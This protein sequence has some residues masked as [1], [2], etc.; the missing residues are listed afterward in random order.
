MVW[1]QLENTEDAERYLASIGEE[2][3]FFVLLKRLGDSYKE[4]G[5]FDKAIELYKKIITRDPLSPATPEIYLSLAVCYDAKN[6]HEDLIASLVSAAKLSDDKTG[7]SWLKAQDKSSQAIEEARKA[8]MTA[9]HLYGTRIHQSAEKIKAKVQADKLRSVA[10]AIYLNYVNFFPDSAERPQ[11]QTYLGRIYQDQEKWLKASRTYT[12][13]LGL[14][15][16]KKELL[17]EAAREAIISV[18]FAIKENPPPAPPKGILEKEMPIPEL[19][20]TYVGTLS[21]YLRVLP[22]DK[23]SA[24]ILYIR[25][26]TFADYGYYEKALADFRLLTETHPSSTHAN[27][28]AL[29]AVS[30]YVQRMDWT[31][32]IKQ[33]EDFLKNLS[34]ATKATKAS[35]L[36]S[37]EFSMFSKGMGELKKDKNKEAASSFLAFT[38]R[39]PRSADADKALTNA[40]IAQM[41][42]GDL[43]AALTTNQT[44]IEDYPKSTFRAQAILESAEMYQAIADYSKAAGLYGRFYKEY[45]SHRTAA[46]SLFNAAVLYGALGQMPESQRKYKDFLTSFPQ[47]EAAP[48]AFRN[49]IDSQKTSDSAGA[50]LTLERYLK[51]NLSEA[52]KLQA[53]AEWADLIQSKDFGNAQRTFSQVRRSLVKDKNTPHGLA[54]DLTANFYFQQAETLRKRFLEAEIKPGTGFNSSVEK[55]QRSLLAAVDAYQLVSQIGHAEKSIATLFRLG[56][57]HEVFAKELLAVKPD[58]TLGEKEQESFRTAIE[59]GA[60]PLNATAA[61]F[62]TKAF[63]L[64]QTAGDYSDWTK[65]SYE[66]LALI[67]P[68][69]ASGLDMASNFSNYIG[70]LL[71]KNSQVGLAH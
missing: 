63:D 24:R 15:E 19:I 49:L 37:L 42:E 36:A 14:K 56:E 21:D 58:A 53:S 25:A 66:K 6:S 34:Q 46:D 67:S 35:L 7:S 8:S 2:G 59:A 41:K 30:L 43:V 50:I 70:Q 16:V 23:D 31:G 47:H 33:I 60:L 45:P 17:S 52:L 44:L 10:Q 18:E 20:T 29:A 5:S 38:E 27:Q 13:V 57:L 26:T 48:S 55:K 22:K 69:K 39:F 71:R 40:K 4:R 1:A 62:Y 3:L 68:V 51:T 11:L 32:A 64:S 54:R 9:M 28:A 12:G 65:K 61:D